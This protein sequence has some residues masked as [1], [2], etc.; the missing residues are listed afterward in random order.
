MVYPTN[1]RRK[2]RIQDHG[3]IHA[4][5]E[6]TGWRGTVEKGT[7]LPIME[8][9]H[10]WFERGTIRQHFTPSAGSDVS[11]EHVCF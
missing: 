9:N 8:K 10:S 6:V 5:V 11:N 4:L 2:R 1:R 7:K 3:G